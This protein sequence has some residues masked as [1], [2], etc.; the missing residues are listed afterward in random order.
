[1][2]EKKQSDSAL[3]DASVV[4]KTWWS[5]IE[6]SLSGEKMLPHMVEHFGT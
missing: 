3:L 1:M 2:F 5:A 4:D 6:G